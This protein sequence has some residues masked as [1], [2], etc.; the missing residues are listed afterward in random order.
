MQSRTIWTIGHSTHSFEEFINILQSFEIELIAD[1]RSLPGSRKHPQ[2]NKE[3][4]EKSFPENNIIYLHL[5]ELGGRRKARPDS[6]NTGW[7][8]PAFRGYADYM[9][10]EEFQKAIAGLEKAASENRTAIMCAESLWWRCHRSLVSDY[11][12]STGWIVIHI[13]GAEKSMEHKFRE[14]AH[15]L[16]GKLTYKS[17]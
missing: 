1:I 14:P 3:F 2:F 10:T 13:M 6:Q 8:L 15:I 5:K 7:R 12:K 9:E 17:V 4:L 11:L 16:E